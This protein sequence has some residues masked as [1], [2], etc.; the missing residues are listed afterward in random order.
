MAKLDDA[1]TTGFY[2]EQ[3]TLSA[4][5]G[6]EA[7]KCYTIYI[8]AAVNS[9]TGGQ[10]HTFKVEAAPATASALATVDSNVSAIKANTDNLPADPADQS[11][12]ASL[13]AGIA[14][15]GMTLEDLVEGALTVQ[16]A[17]RLLL[18]TSV[19]KSGRNA[20]GQRVYRDTADTRNRVVATVSNGDRSDVTLDLS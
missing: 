5:N 10:H 17:L 9:V 20:Q 6:F 3:I 19:G 7:G 16:D 1:N 14:G 15:G 18:A 4:A 8:T 2:S 13:I 11:E 12:L